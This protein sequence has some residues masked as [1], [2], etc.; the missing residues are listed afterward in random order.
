MIQVCIREIWLTCVEHQITLGV[1]HISGAVL[2]DLADL[3]SH[4]HLGQVYKDRVDR[5]VNDRDIA[6]ADINSDCFNVSIQYSNKWCFLN[7]S[8]IPSS[9]MPHEPYQL[10]FSVPAPTPFIAHKHSCSSGFVIITT[11]VSS[12]Q[13]SLRSVI[14][15]FFYI[16][17]SCQ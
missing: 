13:W 10:K 4:W 2:E 11:S 17:T 12:N 3:L 6:I 9:T 1:A 7:Y 16:G 14:M 5:L 15:S 8:T